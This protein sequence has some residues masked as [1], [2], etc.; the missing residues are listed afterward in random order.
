MPKNSKRIPP[1]LK[2]G[3]Y[4]LLTVLPTESRTKFRKFKKQRFA[5][6]AITGPLEE[7][8][9][10]EI[11]GLEW[12]RKHLFTLG[13]AERARILR[14]SI[15]S[16]WLPQQWDFP[17]LAFQP[18]SQ[19][20]S[21]E[22][23]EALRRRADRE[24]RSQLGAAI[25]LVELGEI[26]TYE[27]FEKELALLDRLYAMITRAYKKLSYVRAIKSMAPPSLPV[28]SSTLLENAA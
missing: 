6:L 1:A 13:L 7:D 15:Y 11:V 21:P 5:E 24:I 14:N 28:P 17:D 16:K 23:L 4:S 3:I 18:E 22:E 27:S 25:E 9:G 26:V 20:C 19:K 8:I 2:S 12:R 10:D